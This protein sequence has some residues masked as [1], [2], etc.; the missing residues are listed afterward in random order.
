ML[1]AVSN[2][3][4]Y[5]VQAISKSIVPGTPIVLIPSAANFLAPWKEPSPPITTSPSIPCALQISAPRFC[6]SSVLNSSHLAVKR[7]VPPRKI[8]SA[9]SFGVKS[10]M[11]SFNNPL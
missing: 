7:I 11:S 4:V 1:T 5:S 3:I 6:P 2:P 9:V 10:M 8:V